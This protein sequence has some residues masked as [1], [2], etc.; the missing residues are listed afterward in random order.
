MHLKINNKKFTEERQ[1]NLNE[2][3]TEY[4]NKVREIAE[5]DVRH[6]RIRHRRLHCKFLQRPKVA[7]MEYFLDI[8]HLCNNG[9]CA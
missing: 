7:N 8:H 3:E 6:D 2:A 1:Q 4:N 9:P 5:R